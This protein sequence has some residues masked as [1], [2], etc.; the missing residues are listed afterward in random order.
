M[1]IRNKQDLKNAV[2]SWGLAKKSNKA[3][4]KK[5]TGCKWFR[6]PAS[7]YLIGGAYVVN[8]C[9]ECLWMPLCCCLGIP[10]PY[11]VCWCTNEREENKAWLVREKCGRR[12]CS[13]VIVDE[14]RK[15]L[16]YYGIPCCSH[17]PK[18]GPDCYW[19]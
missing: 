11:T 4:A 7:G 6:T 14:E 8:P 9:D 1:I 13:I 12:A 19:V 5:F 17:E 16:A 18:G 2:K 10:C 3:A 15:T